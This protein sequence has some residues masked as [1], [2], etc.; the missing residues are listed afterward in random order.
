MEK[1]LVAGAVAALLLMKTMSAGKKSAAGL[2]SPTPRLRTPAGLAGVHDVFAATTG[3]KPL[4]PGLYF[5][6]YKDDLTKFTGQREC[7]IAVTSP[8]CRLSVNMKNS[9]R[10]AAR[11]AT[12]PVVWFDAQGMQ[13]EELTNIIDGFPTIFVYKNGTRS[14]YTGP[15]TMQGLAKIF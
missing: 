11:T 14:E 8:K 2:N 12:K 5:A 6:K 13:S 7:V 1:A 4:R 10:K 15:R 9:F 3:A